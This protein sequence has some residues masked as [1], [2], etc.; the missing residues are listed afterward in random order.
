MDYFNIIM[1]ILNVLLF[2]IDINRVIIYL[3]LVNIKCIIELIWIVYFNR[4]YK[5][6][7]IGIVEVILFI[8]FRK[9]SKNFL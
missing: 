9:V 4:I 1:D 8:V 5:L 7:N 3:I 6:L 2:I